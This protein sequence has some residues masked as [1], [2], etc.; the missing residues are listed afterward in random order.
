MKKRVLTI[1]IVSVVLVFI[2]MQFIRPK[3]NYTAIDADDS[4]YEVLS[5]PQDIEA[6]MQQ[7]CTD[8]HSNTTKYPWYAEIQPIGWLLSDHIEKGKEELNLDT[9]GSYSDRRKVSKLRSMRNQIKEDKMPLKSYLLMH[10]EAKLNTE[11]KERLISWLEEAI[12]SLNR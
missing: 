12:D 3:A 11:K 4:F 5:T 9:F 8:C 1:I 10:S 7:S 6:A 2:V